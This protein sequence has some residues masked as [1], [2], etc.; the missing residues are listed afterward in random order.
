MPASRSVSGRRAA[1]AAPATQEPEPEQLST[2]LQ[3]AYSNLLTYVNGMRRCCDMSKFYDSLSGQGDDF[4]ADSIQHANDIFAN[5]ASSSRIHE[6]PTKM[7]GDMIKTPSR[8]KDAPRTR[9]AAANAAA[10]RLKA[11][12]DSSADPFAARRPDPFDK[13]N[14]PAAA[15]PLSRADQ[16]LQATS[17]FQQK[18]IE[19]KEKGSKGKTKTVPFC[20][21]NGHTV[22][23]DSDD[24]DGQP[25]PRAPARRALGEISV[26]IV[27]S[28][29][30]GG[31][32]SE[33]VDQSTRSSTR[34]ISSAKSKPAPATR[35]N[36]TDHDAVTRDQNEATAK[37]TKTTRQTR[38]KDPKISLDSSIEVD[39]TVA[40]R[41]IPKASTPPR[42][43]SP[44]KPPSRGMT[45][46]VSI[47]DLQPIEDAVSDDSDIDDELSAPEEEEEE[48]QAEELA[49]DAAQ[50]QDRSKAAT[51][52]GA[53]T[54]RDVDASKGKK[55]IQAAAKE[56]EKKGEDRDEEEAK[57][58]AEE[59]EEEEEGAQSNEDVVEVEPAQVDKGSKEE[60]ADAAAQ[61]VANGDDSD[62]DEDEDE[63]ASSQE[64][65]AVTAPLDVSAAG[66]DQ[67]SKTSAPQSGSGLE[68]SRKSAAAL[69]ASKLMQ[70]QEAAAE[71]PAKRTLSSFSAKRSLSTNATA[72]ALS[73]AAN[74]PAL[75]ASTPAGPGFRSSFLNKS[76]RKRVE[77]SQ[78]RDKD[79]LDNEDEDEDNE[80]GLSGSEAEAA[81][82]RDQGQLA[83]ASM[84]K[85]NTR[86][87]AAN[88]NGGKGIKRKSD[89]SHAPLAGS[90]A[91][92][93]SPPPAKIVKA[94][95]S[96]LGAKGTAPAPATS[97]AKS[98]AAPLG[99]ASKLEMFRNNLATVT[100]NGSR[101]VP[102]ASSSAF[103][104]HVSASSPSKA[105]PPPTV[106]TVM[107]PASDPISARVPPAN[108]PSKLY[109]SLPE[110]SSPSRAQTK[111]SRDARE[112]GTKSA[113]PS[114]KSP[115]ISSP[116][117][118]SI[119]SPKSPSKTT[120]T[121]PVRL[122][123]RSASVRPSPSKSADRS[124]F[125]SPQRSLREGND[126]RS[127]PA[128]PSVG[129]RTLASLFG[130]PSNGSRLAPRMATTAGAPLGSTTPMSSPGPKS[131]QTGIRALTQ[132]PANTSD[133]AA[134][135]LAP[136]ATVGAKALDAEPEPKPE[137]ENKEPTT[138]TA[139]APS[140]EPVEPRQTRLSAA[141]ARE[142]QKAAEQAEAQTS[143]ARDPASQ[144]SQAQ[145]Q[146][147]QF[148]EAPSRPQS[149]KP[150]VTDGKAP[151]DVH[152]AD[153]E[154]SDS[155]GELTIEELSRGKIK[156]PQVKA[157]PVREA[158]EQE[159]KQQQDVSR[160]EAA[161]AIAISTAS[162]RKVGGAAPSS[163][164][165]R[166][167]GSIRG[168]PSAPNG[169]PM[170][171]KAG[172]LASSVNGKTGSIKAATSSQPT[173]SSSGAT[174][175][176]PSSDPANAQ[177]QGGSSSGWGIGARLKGLFGLQ[178][179]S[180]NSAAGGAGSSTAS[181]SSSS[182][183]GFT[184]RTRTTSITQN[185]GLGNSTSAAPS[186][187]QEARLNASQMASQGTLSASTNGK[188][189]SLARAEMLRRKEA[190]EAERKAKERDERKRMVMA[191]KE[192]RAKAAMEEEQEKEKKKRAREDNDRAKRLADASEALPVVVIPYAGR[193]STAVSQSG[194][195]TGSV[196]SKY[197][198]GTTASASTA[199]TGNGN[200]ALS[201]NGK[202]RRLT[203]DKEAGNMPAIP[204]ALQNKPAP[205]QPG[206]PQRARSGSVGPQPPKLTRTASQ[207]S[208]RGG[209]GA[210]VS[211]TNFKS[212]TTASGSSATASA[213]NAV[214]RP[215]AHVPGQPIRFGAT[216]SSSKATGA[217][218][219]SAAA[220][221]KR[222][223]NFS[224]QN[225]FQQAAALK[226]QQQQQLQKQRQMQQQQ[227]EAAN[228][229]AAMTA[230]QAQYKEAYAEQSEAQ[231]PE[232]LPEVNS[233]YSDS[234][235]EATVARRA[236]HPSWTQGEDLQAALLAQATVDADE[237]FGIPS[238]PVRLEEMLPS[239]TSMMRI[240]RPRSSSAN[241]SGPD[242]LAQWEIDRYNKRLGIRS[243][244]TGYE[245]GRE[246]REK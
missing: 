40:D 101:G 83:M 155:E 91:D 163:Q 127:E 227:Q 193:G 214:A 148:F 200:A 245:A 7:A 205:Q 39:Q 58:E 63:E 88:A 186:A 228:A 141:K 171:Q 108:A 80:R 27:N 180:S 242:G 21:R 224:A 54:D 235:D 177:A 170:S 151:Q 19:A 82:Q 61:K 234:G 233:E 208:I 131:V 222:A 179:S 18:L 78:P 185:N 175:N 133:K 159:Q 59:V 139:I 232:E 77:D 31:L 202:K 56:E 94:A 98:R 137:P 120:S 183:S 64:R 11:Y 111:P 152:L 50:A 100:R 52:V 43:T 153:D 246:K 109:P 213:S 192:K 48:E 219:A 117:S 13:E 174:S 140:A 167:A 210:A 119:S 184:P 87:N 62:S 12:E 203:T 49:Q 142:A 204:A 75:P 112:E 93:N 187:S 220:Q 199:A 92:R 47:E 236:T 122:P 164:Q 135:S 134:P 129:A 4:I 68:A 45:A 3:S 71:K 107:V 2:G 36:S 243:G 195:N 197:M 212:A 28:R 144:A 156:L 154:S 25:T 191:A 130:T 136:P 24:D 53:P 240:R 97:S 17:I 231:D 173:S 162:P 84:T 166:T 44:Q 35:S 114:P 189:A 38:A 176:Q 230:A 128:S 169:R 147:T 76:L 22:G 121:S 201:D 178:S 125:G 60:K 85:A 65:S 226:Q 116:K 8:R 241:W 196:K 209:A 168:A 157:A 14:L 217:A 29:V 216:P 46:A 132:V 225:P 146:S 244:N 30:G 99:P 181:S 188:P 149:Q 37:P 81:G 143:P 55:A 20:P 57:E 190:E 1:A 16:T 26:S 215:G 86:A 5:Y 158:Q 218:A 229:R 165:G 123:I 239:Q 124:R 9:R 79:I 42:S 207:S 223:S 102:L 51:A 66:E 221:Q 70:P 104:R 34:I 72:P 67:E 198:A 115:S 118:P 206:Q 194:Y 74:L 41:S 110:V 160:K 145:N 90:A 211:T 237:I 103:A 89:Q 182:S 113:V 6:S 95:V 33:L 96:R 10:A 105:L 238:G 172:T 126:K 106:A 150:N 138:R 73:A 161:P 15:S 23:Q 69:L 32:P